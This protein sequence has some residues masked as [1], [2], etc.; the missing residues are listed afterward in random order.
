VC[1]PVAVRGARPGGTLAVRI[2][3]VETSEWGYT[4]AGSREM[5]N[6]ALSERL[7]VAD[8][9]IGLLHWRLD[10]RAGAWVDQHGHR[11]ASAPFHGCI[12]VAHAPGLEP[13][14]DP[15]RPRRTGGNLDCRHLVAGSTL[16][17][18][19]EAEGALLSIGDTHGAQGDGELGGMA[20]ECMAARTRLTLSLLDRPVEEPVA[21]TPAGLIVLGLGE[22]MDEA[23]QDA[24][25]RML[26]LLVS[27]LGVTRS[28][29]LALASC[30][31]DVRVTQVV[32]GAV[33]AH[34]LLPAAFL[35]ENGIDLGVRLGVGEPRRPQAQ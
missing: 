9:P 11:V 3:S 10:R 23:V 21:L 22:R 6:V 28:E 16:L 4:F 25:S 30:A 2:E 20:I 7:G 18:P 33:G 8:E 14:P 17:L 24:A 26:D 12:G 29:A 5:P 27:V 31:M 32:N 19:I 35:L 1:G 13:A 15:W 34:A